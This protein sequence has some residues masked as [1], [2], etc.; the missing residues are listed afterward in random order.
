M[1]SAKK[2]YENFGQALICDASLD[3]IQALL[4]LPCF[5][6]SPNQLLE[7]AVRYNRYDRVQ[8]LLEHCE[9]DINAKFPE[10]T[11]L[12]DYALK[13][14]YELI[15]YM[16]IDSGANTRGYGPDNAS[17]TKGYPQNR[18]LKNYLILNI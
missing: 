8:W 15:A 14:G 12:L 7:Y 6:F 11:T 17:I 5:G 16:L 2:S 1:Q 4:P 3:L 13:K 9:C 18:N 10:G